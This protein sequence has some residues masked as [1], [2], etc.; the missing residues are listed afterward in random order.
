MVEDVMYGMQGKSIDKYSCVN[1]LR[2]VIGDRKV[3]KT[4]R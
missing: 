1:V 4:G 2:A 3:Y